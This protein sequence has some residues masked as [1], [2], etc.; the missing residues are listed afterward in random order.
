[1]PRFSTRLLCVTFFG[2]R[3]T[4]AFSPP[5]TT[6]SVSIFAPMPL[7]SWNEASAAEPMPPK[8]TLKWNAAGGYAIIRWRP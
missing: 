2:S 8:V 6:S 1:M 7:T 3:W 5:S 4:K